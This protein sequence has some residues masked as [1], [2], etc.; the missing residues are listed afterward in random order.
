MVD[1]A[2]HLV[3]HVLPHVPMRQW[4]ITFPWSLRVL[5]AAR[6]D[7]LTRVLGI[8]TRALSTSV[9]RRAGLTVRSGAKTG[10]VTAIQRFGSNLGLNVHLHLLVP[11]G[12]YSFE[13]D[14]PSFHRVPA[15]SHDELQRLLDTLIGRITRTLVRTGVLVEDPISGA[16]G[17]PYLDLEP[18]TPLDELSAAAVRYRIVLGPLAGRK[19]MTLHD[20]TRAVSSAPSKPFIVSR[21]GFSLNAAV[22]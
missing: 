16:C 9:I 20:P 1:G 12:A 6:P 11:D 21:D 19:T 8:V 10:I 5:F 7:L 13:Q 2:A 14:R 18:D 4:V 3:D 17:Q 15:P 22:A